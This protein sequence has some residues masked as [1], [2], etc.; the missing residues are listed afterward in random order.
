V[1]STVQNSILDNYID[2]LLDK[3]L[4]LLQRITHPSLM[5][6]DLLETYK[7]SR[8]FTKNQ[9]NFTENAKKEE[10]NLHPK[11]ALKVYTSA[12]IVGDHRQYEL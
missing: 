5:C 10:K 1:L 8:N 9:F 11:H 3:G 12:S 2:K 7:F 4:Y 6:K